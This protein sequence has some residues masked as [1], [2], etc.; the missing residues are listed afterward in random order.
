VKSWGAKTII[1]L[2]VITAFVCQAGPSGAVMPVS[3]LNETPNDNTEPA[4]N[5]DA[6]SSKSGD[7][8]DYFRLK[9]AETKLRQGDIDS[10]MKLVE[11]VHGK[12]LIFWKNV[13]SAEILLADSQPQ[14]AIEKLKD[15][16][17]RPA[18]ELSFEETFYADL[19]KRA[20]LTL[21]EAKSSLGYSADHE[22]AE[23]SANFPTDSDATYYS[24][25]LNVEQKT[26]KLHVLTFA[27]K[28]SL[29]SNFITP[30]EIAE[31]RLSHDK[32]CRALFD[33][34]YGLRRNKDMAAD[35]ITAFQG[36]EDQRCEH[37]LKARALYWIGMLGDYAQNDDEVD[38]ALRKL[39]YEFKGHRLQ[40][41]GFYMLYKRALKRNQTE[42]MQ[43]YLNELM[44]LPKGDM[45]DK[46]AFET[47]FPYYMKDDFSRAAQ[48]LE[49]IVSSHAA[50]E[51]FTQVLY[52][53]ARS[54]QKAGGNDD[55]ERAT[56]IY[57]R[58]VSDYPFSFYASMAAARAQI[59][60]NIP[61]LP[62]LK[63]TKPRHDEGLFD[64]IDK[65]SDGGFH[66]AAG[67]V[68]DLAM[69]LNPEWENK[70]EEFVTLKYIESQNY[71]KALDMAAQH[72]DSSV[73]GPVAPQSDPMF[74]AFFPLAFSDAVTNGYRATGLPRG[75]IEGIMREESLFQTN[76][77]SSAGAVGLMQVMPRTAAIMAR[78]NSGSTG[79]FDLTQPAD[80]VLLGSSYLADMLK[81]FDSQMPLAIMAY[82]AGPGNV[83]KFLRKL[84][85]LDLD[86]FIENIPISETRGYV[87]RVMRSMKVYGSIYDDTEFKDPFFSFQVSMKVR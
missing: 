5:L 68:M 74:A 10:A 46:L 82:N 63:G 81:R 67:Q 48:I 35:A 18:P 1:T 31:S 60:L 51:N 79:S 36:I 7:F 61:A 6:L 59:P 50:D 21:R 64:L 52:W 8:G 12:G 4:S 38:R 78:E 55:N 29:I 85:N 76:V 9:L 41:D 84:G 23:L 11:R 15:L 70:H 86:E 26:V 44:S 13:V 32:K 62:K 42:L 17:P 3:S 19:Y 34:G 49:P 37:N 25:D 83:N 39:A 53:Y 24:S 45:R 56:K 27:Q 30:E 22:S 80:N 57:E 20:L 73:Y 43:K 28:Y 71:R 87:K 58:I 72:F 65:L 69:N 40:D 75:A 54:L 2:S 66:S 47:A 14:K 33:L 16:P 77:R